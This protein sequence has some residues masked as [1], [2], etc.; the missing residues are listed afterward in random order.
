ERLHGGWLHPD[1]WEPA[2]IDQPEQANDELQ[3]VAG[4]KY[5]LRQLDDFS[6]QIAKR[7]QVSPQVAK[8][9]RSG[10]LDERIYLDYSQER[11]SS[12]GVTREMLQQAIFAANAQ[13][14]GGVVCAQLR[15]LIVVGTGEAES[16]GEI[17]DLLVSA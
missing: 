8:V 7:I 2:V 6:D 3:R 5:S 11:F 16:E 14:P 15:A 1:L 10:V 4:S 9:T 17:P 13:A 12:T